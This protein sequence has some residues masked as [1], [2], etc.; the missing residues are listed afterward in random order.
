MGGC[1]MTYHPG[2]RLTPGGFYGRS[3]L[4]TKLISSQRFLF[5]FF[6]ARFRRKTH[7]CPFL[8]IVR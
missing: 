8:L 6:V 5:G 3:N 2:S 7:S 1:T 4:F